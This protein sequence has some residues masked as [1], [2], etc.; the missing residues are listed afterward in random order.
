M[1]FRRS[2]RGP[3]ALLLHGIGSSAASFAP[4]LDALGD[5][6][7]MVAWDA[8]GYAGS[9]DPARPPG[10]DG[11]VEEAAA[12]MRAELGPG[13]AHLVG[14]SWGG[15]IALRLAATRPGLVRSLTVI[16]ASLGSG[17]DPERAAR[18]RERPAE[19]ARLGPT[20]FARERGPRLLSPGARPELVETVVATMAG[21]VR[22]PGYSA[23]AEAMAAADLSGDIARISAPT[24]VLAGAEDTVTGPER[25]RE[26]AAGIPGAALVTVP[27]AGHL[28]N[29]ERPA[30]VGAWLRAFTRLAADLAADLTTATSAAG[31]ERK[32]VP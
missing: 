31:N 16:G 19:L 23:A 14:V 18:M 30:I 15:V 11:Y 28:A 3:G 4:Q 25:A 7:T 12:L 29:Q 17:T 8:P 13:P 27:G 2:G 9:P 6:L 10:L 1:S 20:G 24:L 5:V 21:A 22:L 26:I 32:E